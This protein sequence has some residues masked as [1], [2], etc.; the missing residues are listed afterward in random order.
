[1][2]KMAPTSATQPIT[3]CDEK[4]IMFSFQNEIGLKSTSNVEVDEAWEILTPK[5]TKK[6]QRSERMFFLFKSPNS[7]AISAF[8]ANQILQTCIFLKFGVIY[9]KRLLT[10]F[11][12]EN[13]WIRRLVLW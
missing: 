6:A 10:S 1:M 3:I 12:I 13:P 5:M 8:I 4:D 9:C 7:L 11:F 2:D